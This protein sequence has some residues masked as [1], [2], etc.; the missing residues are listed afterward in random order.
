MTALAARKDIRDNFDSKIAEYTK[1]VSDLL[2]EPYKLEVNFNQF[3]AYAAASDDGSWVKTS[4]GTAAANYFESFI[5]YLKR[6]TDEVGLRSWSILIA[7]TFLLPGQI[8]RRHR[9]TTIT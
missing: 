9:G 6:F 5:T 4:P 7:L 1:T 2:R 3:Y 8:R